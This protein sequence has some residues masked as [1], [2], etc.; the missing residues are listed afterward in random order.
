MKNPF[1]SDSLEYHVFSKISLATDKWIKQ[2]SDV[3]KYEIIQE[4]EE[5]RKLILEFKDKN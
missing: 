1:D 2:E 4:L 3:T 5:I